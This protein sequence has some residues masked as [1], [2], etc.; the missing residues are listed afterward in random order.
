MAAYG[1]GTERWAVKTASDSDRNLVSTTQHPT[2]ID[3]LRGL[4]APSSLPSNHRVAPTERTEYVIAG[5]LT[6][7][8]IEA[9]GD[10]HLVIANSAG[11]TL[12]AAAYDRRAGPGAVR[13]GVGTSTH[14]RGVLRRVQRA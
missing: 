11:R 3:A 13:A 7:Y 12:I 14:L 4:R 10:I 9:D 5:T 8:K 6:G 1:C 2:T